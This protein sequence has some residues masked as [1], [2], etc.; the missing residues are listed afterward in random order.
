[1]FNKLFSL[2][3]FHYITACVYLSVLN[4]KRGADAMNITKVKSFI[5]EVTLLWI[6]YTVIFVSAEIATILVT[7]SYDTPVDSVGS[8]T[9]VLFYFLVAPLTV[10]LGFALSWDNDKDEI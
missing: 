1:M 4:N 6:I 5:K 7:D 3:S 2:I 9:V 10:A 8:F